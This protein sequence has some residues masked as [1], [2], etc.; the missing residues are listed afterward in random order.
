MSEENKVDAK[1]SVADGYSAA[2]EKLFWAIGVIASKASGPVLR[3]KKMIDEENEKLAQYRMEFRKAALEFSSDSFSDELIELGDR[4]RRQK[5]LIES[6]II[7]FAQEIA[8]PV[9]ESEK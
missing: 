1:V 3:V 8:A 2:A 6:K 4:V 5:A 9:G 7:L